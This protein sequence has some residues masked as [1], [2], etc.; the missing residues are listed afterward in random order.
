[1][2]N[3]GQLVVAALASLVAAGCGGSK[4]PSPSAKTGL[5]KCSGINA[6]KGQAACKSEANACAGHNGCKGEG[7]LKI[8][9][10][11]CAKQGGK[12]TGE[13]ASAP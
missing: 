3:K 1:M 2:M 4:Q 13:V 7:Y 10:E 12:A 5:V 8:T 11:E 6:C 9:P